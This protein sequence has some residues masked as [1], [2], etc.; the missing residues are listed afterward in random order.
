VA[1]VGSSAP[2]RIRNDEIADVLERIA[3]L[4]ET[5]DGQRYR[6]RAYRNAV[7]TIREQA[8]PVAEIDAREARPGLERLPGVGKSISSIVHE[9]LHTGRSGLL[10]RL[11]GQVAPEDLFT[12][13]PGIGEDLAGRI[14]RE[15][16][17]ETLEELELAAHD[18]RLER[19]PG[20]GPRR[21][22]GVRDALAAALS[23]SAR[24]RARRVRGTEAR[25]RPPPER[26]PVAT[27]LDVD[28]EYRAR[29]EA[30]NLR[31]IVPR[32]FNPDGK[33]WLPILHTEREGWSFH[34]LYSNTARAH[35]LGRTRDWVVIFWERDGDEDQC[36]VVTEWQGT[37]A[38]R[39]VVRGREAE[40]SGLY[41]ED[42]RSPGSG[43]GG[44]QLG[45]AI[46]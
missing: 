27:L 39:R 30:G 38:G 20:F 13:I 33:A 37:L 14:H 43:P 7:R 29:A 4:L 36:T 34:A 21:V 11:E 22:R 28:A 46:S 10:E 32:R 2:K 1:V 42:P 15:L 31:T 17:I 8:G 26:P 19:V 3:D 16:G 6:V 9:F 25:E 18:G 35:E 40:C 5:Q 45:D 12:T 23:R 24:R 44:S 41:A